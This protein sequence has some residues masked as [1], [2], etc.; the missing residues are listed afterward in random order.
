VATEN[1]GGGVEV[2]PRTERLDGDD[3]QVIP[4]EPH[5]R[6]R[7]LII[8]SAIALI[9]LIAVLAV[10]L[11]H[12]SKSAAKPRVL[13]EPTTAVIAKKK[14]KPA[15]QHHAK[16]KP[17]TQPAAPPQTSPTAIVPPPTAAPLPTPAKFVATATPSSA[18]VRAGTPVNVTLRV[19][20]QGGTAGQFVYDNDG[21][22]GKQLVPPANQ[23]CTE[24]AAILNV[25]PGAT[26]DKAVTISTSGA[27]PGVYKV[28]YDAGVVV[29][30]TIIK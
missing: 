13:V 3:I 7:A 5:R 2:E 1:A 20:N 24:I 8:G 14:P 27:K 18:T 29:T 30:V 12:D 26:V 6:S 9:A 25:A 11:R 19:T 4:G 15:A 22:P 21:C 16:P 10:A 23:I 17:K 28:P